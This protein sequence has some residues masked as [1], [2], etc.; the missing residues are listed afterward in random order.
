MGK[1]ASK[2][3]LRA[4]MADADVLHFAGHYVV[5][6]HSPMSSYLLLAADGGPDSS[7]LSNTEMAAQDLSGLRLIVLAACRI[8]RTERPP[9]ADPGAAARVGIEVAL[10]EFEA[11]LLDEANSRAQLI[12]AETN[13]ELARERMGDVTIRAPTDGIIIS[14]TVEVGTIIQSAS[15]NISGGSII[16]TMADLSEMQVRTLVD[17]TDMGLL[18]SGLEA[19]VIV[20]AFPDRRFQGVIEKIEPQAVVEQ[21]KA[22]PT[23]DPLFG[24]GEIRVDGRKLHDMYLY[25]VKSPDESEGPWDY[26]KLVAKV[27]GEQAFTTVA[28]SKCSLLKK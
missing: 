27:P 5:E 1:A 16:F 3:A 6:P 12:K 9:L 7:K 25:E 20:E 8:E 15:Q 23:S 14:K 22:M 2:P 21:M 26:Y 28:E 19:D 17:E 24:E 18:S 10:E 11:A 4:A 13:V